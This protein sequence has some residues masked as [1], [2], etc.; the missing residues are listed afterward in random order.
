MADTLYSSPLYDQDAAWLNQSRQ[1]VASMLT[2]FGTI[3]EAS[4]YPSDFIHPSLKPLFNHIVEDFTANNAIA[5]FTGIESDLGPE[6]ALLAKDIKA[7]FNPDFNATIDFSLGHMGEYSAR[8]QLAKLGKD[9]TQISGS[10]E[11]VL[12]D[13]E[14]RVRKVRLNNTNFR[15]GDSETILG[16]VR[17]MASVLPQTIVKTYIPWLDKALNGGCYQGHNYWIS[18]AY[19]SGKTTVA[20][21]IALNMLEHGHFVSFIIAES[22]RDML[23]MDF[24]SMILN[25]KLMKDNPAYKPRF[26]G[27]LLF[28]AIGTFNDDKAVFSDVEYQALQFAYETMEKFNLFMWDTRDGITNLSRFNALITNVIAETGCRVFFA[29]H[30]QLFGNPDR[31]MFE[32]QSATARFTQDAAIQHQIS[33]WMLSQLNEEQLKG[34]NKSGESIGVRGGG[35]AAAAAEIMLKCKIDEDTNSIDVNIAHTRRSGKGTYTNLVEILSGLFLE[36][37][38]KKEEVFDS[39]PSLEVTDFSDLSE[40][41]LDTGNDPFN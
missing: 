2:D 8:S 34:K 23:L 15:P 28:N 31:T 19:K 17:E 41:F 24:L 13:L 20:R 29:D 16:E 9:L 18:G 36:T 10:V 21:N 38:F 37:S 26:N 3:L 30:S 12:E 35:D 27:L 25:K 33:F 40:S 22:S 1:V 5:T 11:D 32:R 4:K 39:D 7:G 14:D 6:M